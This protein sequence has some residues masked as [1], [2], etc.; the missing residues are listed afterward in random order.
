[1]VNMRGCL[2]H[3]KMVDSVRVTTTVLRG[4]VHQVKEW[5][6]GIHILTKYGHL[7]EIDVRH[8][9]DVRKFMGSG[10]DVTLDDDDLDDE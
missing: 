1:M 3:F 4:D 8:A 7:F 2:I 9:K 10:K 5:D 6:H